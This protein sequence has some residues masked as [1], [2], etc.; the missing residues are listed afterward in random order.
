MARRTS[1]ARRRAALDRMAH[2]RA[3]IARIDRLCSGTLLRR[4]KRCGK[5]GCRCAEDPAARHGPYYEW[6]RMQGGRLVHRMVSPAAAALLREAIGNYRTVR[7]LLRAW[8]NETVKLIDAE[9]TGKYHQDNDL[10]DHEMAPRCAECK[11]GSITWPRLNR[12][13]RRLARAIG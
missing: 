7:R 1:D 8:E 2:I 9:L 5:P 13:A 10:D 6:G 4:T 12:A 3:R 11:S